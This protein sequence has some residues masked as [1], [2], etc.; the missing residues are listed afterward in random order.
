MA[1]QHR[2]ATVTLNPAID[3]TAQAR[4]FHSG[5]V[6]RVTSERSD[7]GG[8]GLTAGAFLA[9]NGYGVAATGLLGRAN[10]EPFEALF[11]ERGIED[12]FVRVPGSTR[13]NVKLVDRIRERV[14]DI[15]FTG[16]EAGPEHVAEV[17]ATLDALAGEGVGWFILSGSLPRGVQ[18]GI[19]RQMVEA[20]K[21]K[22][23][24]VVLDATGLPL[25]EAL[26]AGP[27]V[28]KQ[29]I[30]ELQEIAG[31]PLA[32][33]AEIV[34]AARGLMAGDAELVAVSMRERGALFV[35]PDRVA[36]AVPPK[37]RIASTVGAGDAIVAGVTHGLLTGMDLAETARLSSAF[38]LGALG[39]LGPHLP[40]KADI[41]A[42]AEL[43]EVTELSGD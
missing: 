12:R 23:C 15:N 28:V 41:D 26:K 35:T 34:A 27:Q 25:A 11:A 13:V 29:N 38:W 24:K 14:T 16:I 17:S 10:L 33:H 6:N 40:P 30:D 43:V 4:N 42:F 5:Q 22:G 1:S 19:Y 37:A 20:L 8:K 32:T 18:P 36:L 9:Q 3:Q 7:A 39:Q 31:K 2:I 21:A